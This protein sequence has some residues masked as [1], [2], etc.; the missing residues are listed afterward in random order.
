MNARLQLSAPA[1]LVRPYDF[2]VRALLGSPIPEM[3]P[4]DEVAPQAPRSNGRGSCVIGLA[5][6]KNEGFAITVNQGHTI[7]EIVG[8]DLERGVPECKMAGSGVVTGSSII[9]L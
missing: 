5:T 6:A 8:V 1:K 9:T 4:T 3:E 2:Y 7:G